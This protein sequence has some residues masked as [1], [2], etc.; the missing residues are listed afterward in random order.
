MDLGSPC[1]CR[2]KSRQSYGRK[3]WTDNLYFLHEKA[4][5]L[6]C[7]VWNHTSRTFPS[8]CR[9]HRRPLQWQCHCRGRKRFNLLCTATLGQFFSSL[10]RV[11]YEIDPDRSISYTFQFFFNWQK[12]LEKEPALCPHLGLFSSLLNFLID[13]PAPP[14]CLSR[15]CGT[16][17][18]LC[19]L[20]R[21]EQMFWNGFLLKLHVP[22]W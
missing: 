8:F 12:A 1:F 7:V 4:T 9:G 5:C 17:D 21:N 10:A 2:I 15:I 18:C 20:R 22:L 19:I 6:C 3:P 11:W 16:P 14:S 13:P